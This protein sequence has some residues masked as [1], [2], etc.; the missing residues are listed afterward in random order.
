MYDSCK[1][2]GEYIEK[3]II[4]QTAAIKQGQNLHCLS[5]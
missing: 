4:L 5:L 2:K 3:F 1:N